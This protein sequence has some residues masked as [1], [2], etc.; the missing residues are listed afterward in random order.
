[1]VERKVFKEGQKDCVH[2]WKQES[3]EWSEVVYTADD[4][5][6]RVNTWRYFAEVIICE[7]CGR[8]ELLGGTIQGDYFGG[9]Y[10][11]EPN[12]ERGMCIVDA[13]DSPSY[14]ALRP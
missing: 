9:E 5:E 12:G 11:L 7:R 13:L 14:R 1:M 10:V 3:R 4:L 2:K 6:R 8:E